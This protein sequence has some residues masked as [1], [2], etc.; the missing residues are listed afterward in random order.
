[1]NERPAGVGPDTRH[2]PKVG[3]PTNGLRMLRQLSLAAD[4]VHLSGARAS[5][6]ARGGDGDLCYAAGM[7]DNVKPKP[8]FARLTL[9]ANAIDVTVDAA[10]T[11]VIGAGRYTLE[12]QAII[13]C[14]Q[15][16]SPTCR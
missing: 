13:R 14:I 7:S 11:A 12:E 9:P 5:A 2:A 3:R 15:P 8:L 6:E 10:I 1:L 16:P 4:P